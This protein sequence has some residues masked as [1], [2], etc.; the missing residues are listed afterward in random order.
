MLDT[1]GHSHVRPGTAALVVGLY[2]GAEGGEGGVGIEQRCAAQHHLAFISTLLEPYRTAYR[3][4]G[5][6]PAPE[7]AVHQVIS[8]FQRGSQAPGFRDVL[9]A[10]EE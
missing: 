1:L 8:L 10:G 9:G 5:A 7:L 4:Q 2:G 6:V 3:G